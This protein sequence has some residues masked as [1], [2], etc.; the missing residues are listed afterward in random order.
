MSAETINIQ[1]YLQKLKFQQTSPA[2]AEEGDN[3]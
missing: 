1:K 3:K 2:N